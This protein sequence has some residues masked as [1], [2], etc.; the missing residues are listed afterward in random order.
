MQTLLELWDKVAE[1]FLVQKQKI[2]E[3]DDTLL[4]VEF[5]RVDKVSWPRATLLHPGSA[6]TREN[7]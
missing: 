3:L 2:K 1:M 5:S 6:P 4:S 7:H